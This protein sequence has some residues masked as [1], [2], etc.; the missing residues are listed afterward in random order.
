[1]YTK[2]NNYA[3]NNK[4]EKGN[5]KEKNIKPIKRGSVAMQQINLLFKNDENKEEE[6]IDGLIKER[7]KNR[8]RYSQ[9]LVM[10]YIPLT[11]KQK[12]KEIVNMD[13]TS[14]NRFNEY[15]QIFDH[16]K[17]QISDIN[18]S[19]LS[20]NILNNTHYNIDSFSN[21]MSSSRQKIKIENSMF[22]HDINEEKD[23]NLNLKLKNKINRLKLKNDINNNLNNNNTNTN[24]TNINNTNTNNIIIG[25]NN[26]DDEDDDYIDNKTIDENIRHIYLN[27]SPAPNSL[28]LTKAK[29]KQYINKFKKKNIENNSKIDKRFILRNNSHNTR[30]FYF[31]P[32][33][34]GT[35]KNRYSTE[36]KEIKYCKCIIF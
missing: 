31:E 12:V 14:A 4:K 22:K 28:R 35:D 6:I 21:K 13:K 29:N 23:I 15:S 27:Y 16:I 7:E 5:E 32:T 11:R 17:N 25:L 24:N 19:L 2:K 36:I 34:D 20:G 8:R 33:L 18:N 1:M 26:S 9:S 3:T 30:D 10:P